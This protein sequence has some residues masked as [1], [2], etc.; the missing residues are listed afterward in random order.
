MTIIRLPLAYAARPADHQ[1][2]P[3]VDRFDPSP[4]DVPLRSSRMLLSAQG[5]LGL[6]GWE[7]CAP[8]MSAGM[9][10]IEPEA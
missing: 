7:F 8:L 9:L 4:C 6:A 5:P 3:E 2:D 10:R 1:P